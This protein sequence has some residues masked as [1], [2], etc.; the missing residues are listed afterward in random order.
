MNVRYHLLAQRMREWPL[1]CEQMCIK[2]RS[3]VICT[4]CKEENGSILRNAE[5][6]VQMSK[7][8][9]ANCD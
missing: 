6:S 4:K 1:E 7:N 9:L 2:Q 5:E 8:A 3:H